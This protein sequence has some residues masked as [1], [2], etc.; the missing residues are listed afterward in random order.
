MVIAL[1][2]RQ[3]I[4]FQI[5]NVFRNQLNSVLEAAVHRVP[6]VITVV[7]LQ[8]VVTFTQIQDQGASPVI[9]KVNAPNAGPDIIFKG[10]TDCDVS[11][12]HQVTALVVHVLLIHNAAVVT[13]RG[14]IVVALR[15][16]DAKR[17]ILMVIAATVTA[18]TVCRRRGLVTKVIT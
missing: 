6:N 15:V 13:V 10:R 9:P 14:A 4:L 16:Q 17:V 3:D 7:K 5:I 1:D 8:D 11:C 18:V 2:A 12:L